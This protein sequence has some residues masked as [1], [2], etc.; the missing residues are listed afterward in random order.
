MYKDKW[1]KK[2]ITGQRIE[3]GT[4]INLCPVEIET[5]DAYKCNLEVSESFY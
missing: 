2:I 1:Y 5:M 4:I 3:R